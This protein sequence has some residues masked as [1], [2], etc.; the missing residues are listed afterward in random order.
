[1]MGGREGGR[2]GE[3][4]GGRESVVHATTVRVQLNQNSHE[5]RLIY[6]TS[7]T[8]LPHY[9][10]KKAIKSTVDTLDETYSIPQL[11]CEMN[12]ELLI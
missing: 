5:P 7:A 3:R 12:I 2:E 8:N 1:M 9:N 10:T 11:D 6:A 4:E